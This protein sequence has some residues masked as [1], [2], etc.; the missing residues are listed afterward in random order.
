MT[1]RQWRKIMNFDENSNYKFDG[2][3]ILKLVEDLYGSSKLK[4]NDQIARGDDVWFIDQ[5]IL[6]VKIAKY[7]NQNKLNRLHVKVSKGIKLDRIW[8]DKKWLD[9]FNKK[10]ESINDVH[11]FH[12][13][14][15]EKLKLLDLLFKKMFS[16]DQKLFIDNYVNEF[17]A[18]RKN[19]TF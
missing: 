1:K 15:I 6:S 8:T 3:S 18:I 13:N 17:L 9:T 11:L 4:I 10:F 12:E 5:S 16:V 19:S 2:K 14:Y 7:L